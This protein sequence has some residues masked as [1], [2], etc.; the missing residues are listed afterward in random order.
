MISD[1]EVTF[2]EIDIEFGKL[3]DVRNKHFTGTRTKCN[4]P[5]RKD[6]D[7]IIHSLTK[8]LNAQSEFVYI[9][10]PLKSSDPLHDALVVV[11]RG[12]DEKMINNHSPISKNRAK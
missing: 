2:T 5:A 1:E 12:S 3:I 9:A 7:D 10:A 4:D 11:K 6:L 8:V